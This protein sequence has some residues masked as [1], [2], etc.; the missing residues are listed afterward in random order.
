MARI[1]E[2]RVL[3]I[4]AIISFSVLFSAA[5]VQARDSSTTTTTF[6]KYAFV[7]STISIWRFP[8]TTSTGKA[9]SSSTTTT[10]MRK[11]SSTTLKL[12]TVTF[13]LYF[14]TTTTLAKR[15]CL[16]YCGNGTYYDNGT[17]SLKGGCQYR[18]TKCL[19]G[20][21]VGSKA[22][23]IL[24]IQRPNISVVS[25]IDIDKDGV[26]ANDN[27]LLVAN[28]GQEDPDED[29]V[30]EACDN[31]PATCN[32]TQC[33]Q[34]GITHSCNT[35]WD[36]GFDSFCR[37]CCCLATANPDQA[38]SDDDGVGDVCDTCEGTAPGSEVNGFGCVGCVD[39]DGPDK[40]TA[41]NVATNTGG[42][43]SVQHT[44]ECVGKYTVTEYT[45]TDAGELHSSNL[46]CGAGYY[47]LGGR[48]CQDSDGDDICNG[49]DNCPDLVNPGQED[50]DGD[51][52]G[53]VCDSCPESAGPQTDNDGDGL[54]NVCDNCVNTPNP[55]QENFDADTFGNACDNCDNVPNPGQ[56]DSDGDGV[57]N[58]CDNCPDNPN[59]GQ[60]NSDGD[61]QGDLCDCDD[62]VRSPQEVGIDCGGP[63]EACTGCSK[64]I[65][66]GD[67]ED[68]INI[69]FVRD[70]DYAGNQAQFTTDIQNLI[71]NGYL[72]NPI[73][74]NNACK[75]NIYFHD[76]EG[77]YEGVCEKWDLPADFDEDCPFSNT[78]VIVFRGA[79][80]ACRNGDRFSVKFNAPNTLL[81]ESGHALFG[82]RDEYCCDGSSS[83]GGGT[84]KNTF[85][86]QAACVAYANAHGLDDADCFLFCP[87]VKCWPKSAAQQQACRNNYAANGKADKDYECSC[88]DYAQET[89]MDEDECVDGQAADC[90]GLWTVHWQGRGIA[91][92]DLGTHSPNWCD[93]RSGGV[94]ECCGDHWQIDPTPYNPANPGNCVMKS[95]NQYGPACDL[96][97]DESFDEI[98]AC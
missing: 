74:T 71:N 98:P 38:D 61:G 17:L 32:G 39:S 78:A 15:S 60:E 68:K 75:Y 69:V 82:L 91:A 48:C 9:T 96:C 67:P 85:N 5:A 6:S 36:I 83:E 50:G 10:T 49:V 27:C 56:T 87:S 51:G 97:G 66:N 59:P 94:Q 46:A 13:R 24:S 86:S 1:L 53:D 81:H 26:I 8:T 62:E 95:G 55:G 28:A 89:G 30:G 63:C 25:A 57:G 18:A 76:G 79:E 88:E 84:C 19:L 52:V 70:E 21:D 23:K 90:S 73:F 35:C 72:A 42:A 29:G 22:C 7:S 11:A 12:T 40:Y 92:P 80:R 33:A 45:C 47:C 44:D 34:I 43:I 2:S 14:T 3:C 64:Y 58:A 37:Y 31:C 16:S 54:G 41:G 4:L 65:Y 20:C 93:Y 77:D